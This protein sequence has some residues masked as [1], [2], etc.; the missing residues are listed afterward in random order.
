MKVN[1][2]KNSLL[3]SFTLKWR[4]FLPNKSKVILKRKSKLSK[5]YYFALFY[6]TTKARSGYYKIKTDC[7]RYKWSTSTYK[8]FDKIL[9]DLN[10]WL[11]FL[12]YKNQGLVLD[13][14]PS[15]ERKYYGYGISYISADYIF[16][17]L[18][19]VTSLVNPTFVSN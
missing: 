4:Y 16:F 3:W 2:K 11:A 19:K 6:E 10:F 1:K 5:I 9:K 18:Y 12:F 8:L 15:Y 17:K 14:L 7:F 13:K